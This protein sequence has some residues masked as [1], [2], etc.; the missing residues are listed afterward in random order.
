M[1]KAKIAELTLHAMKSRY[2][3]DLVQPLEN[4][5]S[6]HMP[7]ASLSGLKLEDWFIQKKHLYIPFAS[8]SDI[9]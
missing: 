2:I 8:S 6:S 7:V 5:R 1:R 9:S 4:E 3:K